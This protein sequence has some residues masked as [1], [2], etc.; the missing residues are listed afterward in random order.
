MCCILLSCSAKNTQPPNVILILTDDQG[1]GDLSCHGNQYINTP[2]MDKLHEE[3][4]RFTDFHVDPTCAP[5]RAAIMTGKYAH[6]AGVWHTIAG[7]NHLRTSEVTMADVFKASG[8]ETGIFGKWH[9]GSNYPY[10]PMDRGFNEWLGQGDGGTGTTDDWFD[11]DRV[12]DYYWHN[13]ERKKIEGY[14]PDVFYNAAIDFIK[15]NKKAQKPFFVYLPTYLPHH[16]HT[17]PDPTWASNYNA[18]VPKSVAHFFAGINRIDANIGRLRKTLEALELA[19]NTILI[20]MSDNGGT[21]GV[22]LFNAG[23]RGRKAQVYEGGHRV[24]FF[25]HWK[26]GALKHGKDVKDLSAHID[27]LPTL[28]DLCG[29]NTEQ[30]VN[31]DG[32]SFKEQLYEPHKKLEERTL[33][34]E[35]QRT[36]K[37]EP[38]V[39]MAAMTNRWRLIDNK[40]LYDMENDFAQTSNV[41]EE[42]PELIEKLRNEQKKYWELVTPNDRERPSFIVGNDLDIETF[43]T[44][45]DWYLPKVPW[46]H[47]QVAKGDASAGEWHIN[48]QS[49]GFYRFEVSRWPREADAPIKGIPSFKGKV[50]DAWV[51]KGGIEKLVYGDE[52]SALP[53][54]AIKIE[55]GAYSEVKTVKETDKTIVFNIKL[56]KG[57]T[58]VKGLLLDADQSIISGAY[59]MYIT[60]L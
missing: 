33:F 3:S 51:P 58:S 46:N 4:V 44:P 35:N 13:G 54:S 8:Y 9:L 36:F 41:I 19:D 26:D 16:P 14:A 56:E 59:Y 49:G 21:Q 30:D 60:K 32:R 29:L 53:V 17:I 43:L 57:A 23:M 39:K 25:I 1:Y 5:T 52:M 15:E 47:A 38:W 6:H 34:V 22:R 12:N 20:F 28:I 10:R 45:S 2:N 18:K 50:V 42:H 37:S 55:V 40:E 31:F 7:G 27:I 11:N 48:V 24:P